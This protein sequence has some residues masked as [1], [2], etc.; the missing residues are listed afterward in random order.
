MTKRFFIFGILLSTLFVFSSCDWLSNKKGS[1]KVDVEIGTKE[2]E[3]EYIG[4]V[5]AV[6]FYR[7]PNAYIDGEF[8]NDAF[9]VSKT[10]SLRLE[11]KG[12]DLSVVENGQRYHVTV[13]EHEILVYRGLN[14]ADYVYYNASCTLE[15]GKYHFNY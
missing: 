14:N 8:R 2:Q 10:K 15:D 6:R 4:N 9:E 7:Y 1:N 11:K 5:T 3:F 13:M 12:S